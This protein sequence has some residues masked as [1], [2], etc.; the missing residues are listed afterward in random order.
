MR[1]ITLLA[2]ACLAGSA[3]QAQFISEIGINPP[4]TDN[5]L[6]FLELQGTAGASLAGLTVI[7]IEGDE[8]AANP[9]NIDSVVSLGS[10]SFG[11]NGLLLVRDSSTVIGD[12]PEAGTNVVEFNFTPDLENAD[13]QTWMLVRDFTGAAGND[14]DSNND[15][16]LDSTP[17]SSV[18][19]SVA[20]GTTTAGFFQYAGQVGGTDMGINEGINFNDFEPDWLY[21][22]LNSTL[23]GPF[24]WA[25]ADLN[26]G[27]PWVLDAEE[28][29]GLPGYPAAVQL[30]RE[31]TTVDPGRINAG[32]VPEPATMIS[33]ALGAVAML[34]RR[35][36]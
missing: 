8:G 4:G 24:K 20:F 22:I 26:S 18:V 27:T 19:D 31:V 10:F 36:K 34:R 28:R 14:L 7:Q 32:V 1:K 15:G 29:V 35:K 30:N 6:E 3:V 33:L 17:W 23:D 25:A 9:G 12:G 21:R 13:A 5:G 2:F 16:V 11:S